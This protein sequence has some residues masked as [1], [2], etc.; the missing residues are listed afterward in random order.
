VVV[1]LQLVI[2]VLQLVIA[3]MTKNIQNQWPKSK[4]IYFSLHSKYDG[5]GNPAQ[6]SECGCNI[7]SSVFGPLA[8]CAGF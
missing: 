8:D 7:G 4:C 3:L 5:K 1:G 6:E 2:V